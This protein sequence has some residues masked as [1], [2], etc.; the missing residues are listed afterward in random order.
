MLPDELNPA[1]VAAK[2]LQAS[3]DQMRADG[4]LRF[5]TGDDTVIEP[6]AW[7][8]QSYSAYVDRNHAQ[9]PQFAGARYDDDWLNI[10]R[11]EIPRAEGDEMQAYYGAYNPRRVKGDIRAKDGHDSL[12]A[13]PEDEVSVGKGFNLTQRGGK[14]LYEAA[15]QD[16]SGAPSYEDVLHGRKPITPVISDRLMDF[17]LYQKKAMVDR[18]IGGR[19]LESRKTAVL[20][21]LAYN[22]ALTRDV[23]EAIK[24][25]KDDATIASLIENGPSGRDGKLKGRR[26]AEA[27][28]WRGV[29]SASLRGVETNQ[30]GYLSE[31]NPRDRS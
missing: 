11:Q 24:A 1:A 26:R 20:V 29:A 6:K 8:L 14:Q 7:T 31:I 23:T 10:A 22:G 13:T 16:I 19:S 18:M 25:G 27:N 12:K 21:S 30:L 17:M 3:V 9:S 5:T 4:R 2:H 15:V 28:M